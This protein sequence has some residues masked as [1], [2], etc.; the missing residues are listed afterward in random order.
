MIFLVLV[1]A[2]CAVY[3][4]FFRSAGLVKI[5]QP[6][7]L[8]LLEKS[9]KEQVK[10]WSLSNFNSEYSGIKSVS[11]IKIAI[12]DSG[13]EK[14]HDDLRNLVKKEYNAIEPQ[15][16]V[17]DVLGHGTT[18]AGII[19]AHDNKIGITGVAAS[20]VELYD[21]KVL[22]DDGKGK[23]D[24]LV[25]GINWSIE[26]NADVL[27]IS[28]GMSSNHPELERVVEK[29]LQ[30]GIIVIASAG[31]NYGG[32]V[33]YP[34]NYKDVISVTAVNHAYN[35]ASFAAK[36]GKIDFA[37]PGVDVLTTKTSN[38]YSIE[39]G[40]SLASAHVTGI[41]SLILANKETFKLSSNK[42]KFPKE[43]YKILEKNAVDIGDSSQIGNGF[44]KL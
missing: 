40:T 6:D 24:N 31:N 10:S 26:N 3:F 36:N 14:Q 7:N 1:F 39:N 2:I 35:A 29:A 34:A 4:F 32:K 25:Q 27:N 16:P 12:L 11:K 41:V 15:Q 9:K 22:D 28:F 17:I 18:V 33:E 13:I 43:V 8:I 30:K 5:N 38:G 20:L 23:I 37:A 19:A 44:I 42:L 21:V